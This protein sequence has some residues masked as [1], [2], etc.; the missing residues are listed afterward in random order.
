MSKSIPI[1]EV[2]NESFQ[3]GLQRWGTVIRLAWAPTVII[4][5]LV[6]GFFGLVINFEMFTEGGEIETL[7]NFNDYLRMPA[8]AAIGLGV[9]LYVIMALLYCG[10]MASIFRLVALGE[11]QPGIINVRLDGPAWRVFWASIILSLVSTLIWLIAFGIALPMTG[12]SFGAYFSD[13]GAFFSAIMVAA[14]T[15]SEEAAAAQVTAFFGYWK[16]FVYAFL[17][18]IVPLIYLNVRLAPFVAGSA[19][20]NRLILFGSLQLTQGRFWPI[21]GAWILLTL[22]IFVISIVF[23]LVS[24]IFEI[25]MGL[26][27]IGG[28]FAIITGVVAIIYIALAIFYYAVIYGAQLAFHAVIYRRLKTGE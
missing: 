22:M 23:E 3:F 9:V 1:A 14:Q 17:I 4:L 13:L 28:A 18:A 15:G 16:A 2:L 21:L 19:A 26:G 25:L 24:S 12:K 10:V 27:G 11:D 20:E 6:G 7:Q 5:L 8:P